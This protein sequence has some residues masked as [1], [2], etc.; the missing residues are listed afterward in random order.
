VHDIAKA[1]YVALQERGYHYSDPPASF[2]GYGQKVRTADVIELERACT[3]LDSSALYASV[4]AAAGLDPVLFLVDGHAFAGYQ[5]KVSRRPVDQDWID[6]ILKKAV[7]DDANEIVELVT[8]GL[9]QPVDTNSL[10]DDTAFAD[11]CATNDRYFG[12]RT[13]ELRGMVNVPQAREAGVP[14]LPARYT[15]DGRV[16]VKMP[17][18]RVE[19]I[20]A[21]TAA[22][23]ADE[24][25]ASGEERRGTAFDALPRVKSWLHS[26]LDLSYTNPPPQPHGRATRLP[27][28]ARGQ[29]TGQ[30]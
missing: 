30:S 8:S 16:E 24:R 14:A 6:E 27:F 23:E 13:S 10:T 12:K 22:A 5:T 3:C 26:L 21:E 2:E 19:R 25:T 18:E 15:V 9:V 7:V 28:R 17:S 20:L 1:V 29:P 4:L 11:A